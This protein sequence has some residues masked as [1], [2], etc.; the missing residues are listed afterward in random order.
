[1]S[2]F[3]FLEAVCVPDD[4]IEISA[5]DVARQRDPFVCDQL[6]GMP[7][8]PAQITDQLGRVGRTL[9]RETNK[10][11]VAAPEPPSSLTEALLDLAT[12]PQLVRRQCPARR[13][14]PFFDP[15]G[16]HGLSV[17]TIEQ[18]QLAGSAVFDERS[19]YETV[20]AAHAPSAGRAFSP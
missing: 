3:E 10:L 19:I 12:K 17:A 11:A 9:E 1:M 4:G 5:V 15:I 16:G 18:E 6:T 14:A 20:T 13:R 2:D 7:C 8:L